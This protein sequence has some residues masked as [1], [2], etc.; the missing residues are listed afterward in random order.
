[1]TKLRGFKA[2]IY[3]EKLQPQMKDLISPPYDVIHETDRQELIKKN[4]LNSVQICLK[5]PGQT[6]TD[7]KALFED[8]KEKKILDLT[9]RDSLYLIEERF[10]L[11]AKEITR[12]G[13]VGLLKVS[14]FADKMILPH[15]NTLSGPKKDRLELLE[16]LRAEASQVFFCYDDPDQ[17]IE[18]IYNDLKF[19]SPRVSIQ[20]PESVSR[21]VWV[22]DQP[23]LLKNIENHFS[24]KKLLIAD[25]HH[26]Y[27]T[28]LAFSKAHPEKNNQ[29]VQGYFT[30]RLSPQFEIL[31]IHRICSLPETLTD[32]TFLTALQTKFQIEAI[33]PKEAALS[34]ALLNRKRSDAVGFILCSKNLGKSFWISRKK[35]SSRDAEIF[36]LQKDV[37]HDLFQ[38][39]SADIAKEKLKFEHD[40][41]I[42]LDRLSKQ[43]RGIGF[44]LPP[45]DLDLVMEV[46]STGERMPQKSTFFY[47]KI[48]SGLLFYELGAFDS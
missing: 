36:A 7:I 1:M 13:F 21:K 14:D 42:F 44:Y 22:I 27:E 17:L 6:Y 11:N 2:Y 24:K 3:S 29:Y 32:E 33:S 48:A 30:N 12:I 34:Q 4:P 18:K 9:P 46:V 20:D 26:R 19:S 8:W 31:A 23:Q 38:W 37:F 40:E 39:T 45:T 47:P 35:Q 25:G 16:T 28:A 10:S 5:G 15:E 41:S 43:D